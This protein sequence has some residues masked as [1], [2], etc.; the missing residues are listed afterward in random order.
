MFVKGGD[1]FSQ[2]IGVNINP[3]QDL[4]PPSKLVKTFLSLSNLPYFCTKT[5][6]ILSPARA[7]KD[8]GCQCLE[9]N[10]NGKKFGQH[11]PEPGVAGMKVQ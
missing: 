3:K 5:W 2:N 1:F 9:D 6:Q 10:L 11:K 4:K 8:D 7:S